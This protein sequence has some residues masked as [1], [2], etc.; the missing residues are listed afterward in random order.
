VD[1]AAGREANGRSR[2]KPDAQ[3]DHAQG[4]VRISDRM[5]EPVHQR[6]SADDPKQSSTICL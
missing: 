3:K 2:P 6:L 4:T 5:S 1:P